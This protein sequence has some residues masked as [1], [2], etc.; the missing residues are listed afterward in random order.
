ME[1]LTQIFQV[2][3]SLSLLMVWV[4]RPK[5]ETGYRGGNATNMKEEF[6]VYG[7]PFW[8]MILIGILKVG[9]ALLLIAGLWV[10]QLTL[11]SAIAIALLMA[12]ALIMHV[13]VKDPLK[14]SLPALTLL[15]L[16]AVVIFYNL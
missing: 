10:E 13:R 11:V 8:F 15:L 5:M 2:V 9:F 12:G 3:I 4:V 7:L 16:S 6:G 1:A 14:K